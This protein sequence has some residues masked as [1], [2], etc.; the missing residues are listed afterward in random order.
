[1]DF[2][3]L[4]R[5]D[6][7]TPAINDRIANGFAYEQMEFAGEY[8]DRSAESYIDRVFACASNDFPPELEYEGY[9]RCDP[10]KE[11]EEVTKSSENRSRFELARSDLYMV[12]YSFIYHGPDGP[13]RL[14]RYIYVPFVLP[15]S[16]LHIQGNLYTIHPVL[17]DP[18]FSL[19][20]N[21]LFIQLTRTRL[22]FERTVHHFIA[23][24]E[25]QMCY[26]VWSWAHSKVRE[27]EKNRNNPSRVV[28]STMANYLFAA[29]GFT[30]TMENYAGVEVVV[31]TQKEITRQK[32]PT[33]EWMVCY[34][35]GICPRG[36]V[37]GTYQWPDI[38]VAVPKSQWN[39]QAKNLIG[40]L[41][42]IADHFPHQ[43]TAAYIDDPWVWKITLGIIIC[44]TGNSYGVLENEVDSHMQSLNEYMDPMVIEDLHL[45]GIH[46]NNI[47]ELFMFIIETLSQKVV[48]SDAGISSIYDKRL[49]VL[50]YVLFD[51]V[52]GINYF[53][54]GLRNVVKRKESNASK[55]KKGERERLT[56][57]DINDLLNR[58]IH[59][60]AFRS[61]SNK[62][63]HP[64]VST[65]GTSSDNIFLSTTCIMLTQNAA[66]GNQSSKNKINLEDPARHLHVSIAEIGSYTNL[67]KSDPSGRSRIN[68]FMVLHPNGRVGRHEQFRQ[69]LDAVQ[70]KMNQ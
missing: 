23:N 12:A 9:R 52:S 8:T 27:R 7:T 69:L 68:P 17:T 21:S 29:H 36:W 70:R 54:Y 2:Q 55:D 38:V 51:I 66:S 11:F 6:Q 14:T 40:G 37:S 50:R 53:M 3:L 62:E 28:Y 60:R 42:Y 20:S 32:Y 34:S 22:T 33:N 13:Q 49:S 43:I 48:S 47:Y 57:K 45:N 46:V 39:D 18:G 61:L 25:Q 30:Q 44:G 10:I 35:R 65:V 16:L 24:G 15:G 26:V 1:M 31:G 56:I 41:F 4:Q 67:P 5:V 64:E 59:M 19:G 58:N 63:K